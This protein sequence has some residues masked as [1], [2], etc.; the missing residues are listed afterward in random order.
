[1]SALFPDLGVAVV[2]VAPDQREALVTAAQEESSIIA[3]EPERLVY[4]ST[5]TDPVPGGDGGITPPT[6]ATRT[7][8]S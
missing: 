4:I 6:A 2:G 8:W 1:M 5:I 7:S 3:A